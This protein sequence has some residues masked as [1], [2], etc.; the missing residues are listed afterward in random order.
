MLFV[1]VKA[2]H[3]RPPH[4]RVMTGAIRLYEAAMPPCAGQANKQAGKGR[5]INPL[6]VEYPCFPVDQFRLG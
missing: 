5:K 2:F 4:I 6:V 3:E 1:M